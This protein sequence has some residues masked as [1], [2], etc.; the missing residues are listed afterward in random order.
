M[1]PFLARDGD[2]VFSAVMSA[3]KPSAGMGVS[4]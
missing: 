3:L 4:V 1:T 2:D